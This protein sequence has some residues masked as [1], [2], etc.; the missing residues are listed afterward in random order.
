MARR[1]SRARLRTTIALGLAFAIVAI[2][3]ASAPAVTVL[4][5]DQNIEAGHDS[6]TAGR[7]EA[8]RTTASGSG[9]VSRISVYV[10][11]SSSATKLTAGL[12]ASSGTH[13]G[14][15]LGQG[16]LTTVA[17]GAWNDVAIPAAQVV[18]GTAYWL[19]IL[20]PAG[21]GTL[22]F[23]DSPHSGTSETSL[24]GG[25][26]S[27]PATWA[28]GT[29][30][31][32]GPLSAYG[33]A[34]VAP[35]PI[36]QV[37]PG[38][39]SFAGQVG[40]TD[41]APAQVT[42]SNAGSGTL[43]FTASSDA[44]W[45]GVAPASGSA[46]QTL[47]ITASLSGLAASAYTGHITVTSPGVQ[48][49][50]AS[51]TVTLTVAPS[52]P[53]S[54]ADWPM[55]DHDPARSGNAAGETA[56]SASN[57]AN[58]RLSWSA[59]LD[60]KVTAQPLFLKQVT[61]GGQLHDIVLAGTSANSLYALDATTGA[62]LWRKNFGAEAGNCAIPGGFGVTG[63]PAADKANARVYTVSDDGR[64]HVLSLADGSDAVTPLQVIAQP[65]TNKVWGGLNLSGNVLYIATAS[66]GCDTE[67][68]R[69]RVYRVDLNG[70]VPTVTSTF[71][72]VP[73]LAA[74][75]GG[76]GIWG[77]GGVSVDTA[78]GTV[79]AATGADSAEGYSQYANRMI[80][81]NASLGLLGSF[82]PTEP[83]TF[84]CSGA[85]CDLDFGSTP[86]VFQPSGCPTMTAAGNKNGTLYVFRTSDLAANGQPAQTLQVN[87]AND[88][89]GS[90]GLGGV[91]AYWTAG[92]M[93]FV[94]DVGAGIN[95]IAGGVVGLTIKADCSLSVAWSATLGNAVPNSTPTVANGVVYVGEGSTGSV[96]AY[97]A[98]TGAPL[99]T[100]AAISGG[101]TYAAPIVADG[102]LI[103][104][105]WDGTS[106]ASAGTIRAYAPGPADITPPTVSITAPS[107]GATLSG[108]VSVAA[109]ASDNTGVASVQLKLDGANLGPLLTSVPYTYSWDTTTA[110]AGGH[111][112][113]AVA[114]DDAG[115]TATAANVSVTVNNAGPPPPT[116][117]LGDQTVEVQVDSDSAGQAEAFKTSATATGTL[118]QVRFY[119]DSSSTATKVIVGIYADNAGKVGALLTQ[120]TTTAPVG[121]AWNQ[122]SV[123]GVGLAN[124]AAYWVA[125]LAPTGSGVV[126]FRD[127]AGGTS[128]T[129][130]ATTLTALPATW[131][132]GVKY[133]DGPL[134]AYGLGG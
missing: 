71:D 37:A 87:P 39:L 27:L 110:S 59:G 88:W 82:L 112:L 12:Y 114:A 58:L 98:Q 45:L 64:L 62:V 93:L 134:S 43:P 51:V 77:Y 129:S 33:V 70:G 116:V 109:S 20:S 111:T 125:I 124:G 68:W 26:G 3:A 72:V 78:A 126:R 31:T 106:A 4:L 113:S 40:G 121:G 14:A 34:D 128:E 24:S 38:T 22:Q 6:D 49:S 25:L 35:Q 120:A 100:S 30:Y 131:V 61:V 53:P 42:V 119:L 54:S 15:L 85:P 97:D 122:V 57:A 117:L 65:A 1:L 11:A 69:G 99:W 108:I 67:P 50:P 8:F 79:F 48:G 63:A 130:S 127:R 46:P 60:G 81:L 5:G 123:P 9:S 92:R 23:R 47:Q 56:I 74:P 103:A 75:N 96:H 83:A 52:A 104:G 118:S 7:A 13:P 101:A 21:T 102:R 89:L 76:G 73:G 17:K 133:T 44:S 95:G 32:D 132:T 36:L 84:P 16:T 2:G 91:P 80:A 19:A 107:G 41:P 94:T 115:N 29:G 105:S 28:S 90:G 10:D 18:G 66:D 55:V 86:V